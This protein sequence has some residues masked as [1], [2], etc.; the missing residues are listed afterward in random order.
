MLAHDIGPFLAL[1]STRESEHLPKLAF[2]SLDVGECCEEVEVMRYLVAEMKNMPVAYAVA[3]A[4]IV[5]VA[6]LF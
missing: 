4:S 5:L 1:E 2:D 6:A 3:I